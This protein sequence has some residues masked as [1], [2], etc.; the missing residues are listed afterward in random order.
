MIKFF[1]APDVLLALGTATTRFLLGM[2][3]V[4]ILDEG[5]VDEVAVVVGKE[6]SKKK[7]IGL[8]PAVSSLSIVG[9][10]IG[11]EVRAKMV[12]IRADFVASPSL[13]V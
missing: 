9:F 12:R 11:S 2:T 7:L 8:G 10:E 6:L 5:T 1:S 4:L 13:I 3:L